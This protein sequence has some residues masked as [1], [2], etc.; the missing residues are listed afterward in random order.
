MME[1]LVRLG[2]FIQIVVVHQVLFKIRIMTVFVMHLMNVQ[3]LN[4]ERLVMIMILVQ[5]MI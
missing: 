3:A 2:T 4:Q 5:Q 1:I